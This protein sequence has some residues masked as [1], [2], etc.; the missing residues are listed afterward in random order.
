MR[1]VQVKLTKRPVF[2]VS[3]V[4]EV[5]THGLNLLLIFTGKPGCDRAKVGEAILQRHLL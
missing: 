4:A 1:Q 2:I 3:G 5:L